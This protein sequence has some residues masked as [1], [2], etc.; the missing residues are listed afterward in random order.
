[1]LKEVSGLLF[2]SFLLAL[3]LS[4]RI[5]LEQ[6]LTL[7]KP[8]GE[9]SEGVQNTLKLLNK[10]SV[11][12]LNFPFLLCSSLML[13]TCSTSRAH[14]LAGYKTTISHREPQPFVT[15]LLQQ[16]FSPTKNTF[17]SS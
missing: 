7:E 5:E 14:T 6:I 11:L 12:A 4:L 2:V 16:G 10:P 3:R 17:K 9:P 15:Q 8:L 1:M 13:V